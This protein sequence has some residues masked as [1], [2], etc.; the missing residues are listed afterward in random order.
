VN[1]SPNTRPRGPSPTQS[2]YGN[3]ISQ[4]GLLSLLMFFA[5]IGTLSLALIAGSKLVYDVF[6]A[7]LK[8]SLPALPAKVFVIGLAYAVGWLSAMVAIRV[9]G[10]LVL[11][12]LINI[13]VWICLLGVCALYVKILQKLYDQN[14]DVL[15]YWAYLL[16]IAAGLAA[17]VGLH[18]IIEGHDLRPFS[19]PLLI[20][21][22]IQLGLIV[23]RYVFTGGD[24][25]FLLKDI[26]FFFV[27][28]MVGFLMLAHLGVL[29]P[30]RARLTNYFDNN[31]HV[32]RTKD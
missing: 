12:F 22:M 9:Y 28:A 26:L 10:N 2:R 23:L 6:G 14:Y 19:I 11:P 15:H 8:D 5:S 24:S 17:T 31:S 21:S 27:M 16:M 13:F 3:K 32:I 30:L 7:G 1:N 29:T 20:I 18:L 25:A 4:R